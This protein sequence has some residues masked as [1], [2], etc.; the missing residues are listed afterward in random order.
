LEQ[1]EGVAVDFLIL[2]KSKKTSGTEMDCACFRHIPTS[3]FWLYLASPIQS[4]ARPCGPRR[5]CDADATA[6]NF[7]PVRC[8]SRRLRLVALDSDHAECL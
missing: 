7:S 8:P 6:P 2:Q 1:A 5:S 4:T 3:D